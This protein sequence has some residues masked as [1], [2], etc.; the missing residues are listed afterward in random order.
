MLLPAR[1][2]RK[3]CG[4]FKKRSYI[5]LKILQFLLLE[6][7]ESSGCFASAWKATPTTSSTGFLS[8]G[9][10]VACPSSKD[11]VSG[12]CNTNRNRLMG[13]DLFWGNQNFLLSNLNLD[14]IFQN[15]KQK[16]INIRVFRSSNAQDI[17]NVNKKRLLNGNL[18]PIYKDTILRLNYKNKDTILRLNFKSK[19][20]KNYFKF[21]KNWLTPRSLTNHCESWNSSSQWIFETVLP[22]QM[23]SIVWLSDSLRPI[24]N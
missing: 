17:S 4:R 13:G 6:G 19:I 8:E 22:S 11:D 16:V 3:T 1:I 24:V 18:G 20:I 10:A 14:Y 5:N 9:P 23:M 2:K 21:F 15:V 7:V 12:I